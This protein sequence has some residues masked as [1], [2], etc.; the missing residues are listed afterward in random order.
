MATVYTCYATC[1]AEDPL[2]WS[3]AEVA[4][5]KGTRLEIAVAEHHK[6][7]QKLMFWRDRLVELEGYCTELCRTA[8]CAATCLTPRPLIKPALLLYLSYIAV[9]AVH[10][11]VRVYSKLSWSML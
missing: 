6:I 7:L 8:T 4:L 2:W 10:D 3:E 1:V 5:L 11:L 9:G